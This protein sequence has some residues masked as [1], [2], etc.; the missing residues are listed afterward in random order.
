VV[1]G[2]GSEGVVSGA[3][4]AGITKNLVL[5]SVFPGELTIW[6][7]RFVLFLNKVK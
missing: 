6:E 3:S 7:Y 4:K 2:F 1:R 5:N